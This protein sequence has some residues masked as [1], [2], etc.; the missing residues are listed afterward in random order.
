MKKGI[1][2]FL[3]VSLLATMMGTTAFAATTPFDTLVPQYTA[4][5][6]DTSNAN[7]LTGTVNGTQIISN[8]SFIDISGTTGQEAIA[9]MAALG[10]VKG[11]GA[12]RYNPNDAATG[13]D[14][15]GD[16]VRLLGS[17]AAVMQ[18][19]YNQVG[20][21]S[22]TDY[23]NRL[24]DQEVLTEAQT[25]GIVPTN[26]TNEEILNLDQ[27][28]TKE[29]IAVWTARAIGTT[30]NYNQNAVFSFSDWASVNPT[31]R[32][33]IEDLVTQGTVPLRNDGTFGPKSTLTRGETAMIMK[34]ALESVAA[35]QGVASG[36]GLVIGVKPET[37]Y[38]NDDVIS[39]NTVTVQNTDGTVTQLVSESHSKNDVKYDYVVYK[40]GV[41]SNGK[42]LALGDEVEYITQNGNLVYAQVMN[43]DLILEKI[44]ADAEADVYSTFH[45]GTVSEIKTENRFNNGKSVITEI[46]RVVDVSGDVFDL[47]VDEDSYTGERQDIVTYKAGAVGGVHLL[48]QGD[49]IEYLVNGNNEVVY[50]KVAPLE[51]KVISGT[52]REVTDITDESPAQMTVY[53]YDDQLYTL[54]IAPYASLSINDRVTTIDNFVYGMPVDVKVVNGYIMNASAESYSAEPGYIPE[55]GKMRM[56]TVDTLYQ[57]SFIVALSSGLKEVYTVASD[58]QFTKDGN[59]VSFSALKVGDSVKVYFSSIGE[60]DAAKVEIEAPEVLFESIY[61][62][63]LKTVNNA[64]GEIQLVGADGVSNPQ[65]ITNNT[66][67]S[68]DASNIALSIDD[69]TD[70]YVGNQKLTTN[71]L[72]RKYTGYRVYAVVKSVYGRPTVVKLTVATGRES[73]YSSKVQSVDQTLGAFDIT[74][75][76]NFALTEGTIVIKDGLVVPSSK[77][78]A[79]DTVFI[80]AEGGTTG[81][82][83]ENA[84]VVKLVTPY[85]NIFDTIRIGAV[86]SVGTNTV[87][88]K[89]YTFYTNNAINAVDSGTSG[90]YKF[91][92][93]T[94]IKDITD[95]EDVLTINP[96]TFYHE[97]YSRSENIDTAYRASIR[98]LQ[99]KR[100]YTFMVLSELDNSILAM[101]MRHKGLI[102]GEEI[103]DTLYEE[104]EIAKALEETYVDAVLSRGIV[105]ADDTTW[106]RFEITDSH[107]WTE[108]TGQWTANTANIYVKYTDAI[109]IKNN[110]VKSVDDIK[111]GDYIYIMRIN[112]EAL[113][114]F[115]ED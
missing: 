29:K 72:E 87:T 41:I 37:I 70:I 61:K 2:G 83:Q 18:R 3:I 19:V 103:D 53:G 89:N 82:Y 20:S 22:S 105:T 111:V 67:T 5:K 73:I 52:V 100:Y 24:I 62:G 95:P 39:R 57:N 23:I 36:F 31:Y 43:N 79:R 32:A 98:G 35:A 12:N 101:N 47:L 55:Y 90:Y 106:D 109:V 49:I 64:R 46:Y 48:T 68:A 54:P 115:V 50:I 77:I 15:L 10:I 17:E 113:I 33:L 80:I 91:Y 7:T 81:S 25:L 75:K 42:Y 86:E 13:Y 56:G 110:S 8:A 102:D 21:S 1:A 51:E 104:S 69:Q 38:Q 27:A 11:Y 16:L 30:A 28:A 60:A 14:V 108:Y 45:Y 59:V 93:D 44:N 88:L 26:P 63:K 92:T 6:V 84:M 97:S 107:D 40:N 96:T 71:D 34:S 76:Q 4:M 94:V 74:L 78:S 99:Y 65:Y 112:E 114:I 85:D 66:W 58:T 9:R